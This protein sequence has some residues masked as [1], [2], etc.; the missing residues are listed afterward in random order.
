MALAH[1]L[2]VVAIVRSGETGSALNESCT[3][4]MNG[5]KID[6]HV[7]ELS[8]VHPDV[9]IFANVDVLVLDIDPSNADEIAALNAIVSDRFPE[10]PVVA[11]AANASLQD[12]RQLMRMGVVDVVPQP[13]V[14]NDLSTAI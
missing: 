3:N 14:A 8:D 10:T 4:N 7:G 9:E 13:V 2:N 12:V 6:V 11:T 5:T 1:G